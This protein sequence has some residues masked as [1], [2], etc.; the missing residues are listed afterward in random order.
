MEK[1]KVY[2]TKE[3]TSEAVVK[4]YQKLGKTLPG[5]VAVKVHSGEEWGKRYYRKTSKING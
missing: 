2:F 5:K 1:P 4:I 3:L